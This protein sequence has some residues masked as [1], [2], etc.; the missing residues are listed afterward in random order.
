MD[1]KSENGKKSKRPSRLLSSFRRNVNVLSS[2]IRP[3]L[4]TASATA[5]ASASGTNVSSSLSAADHTTKAITSSNTGIGI[6]SSSDH[7]H[8]HHHHPVPANSNNSKKSNFEIYSVRDRRDATAKRAFKVQ[9]PKK[10]LYYTTTVFLI[11]PLALFLW[12]ELHFHPHHPATHQ[13]VKSNLDR[14][15]NNNHGHEVYPTW[16]EETF[17]TTAA[18]PAVPSDTQDADDS[19]TEAATKEES[20]E[21]PFADEILTAATAL[22]ELELF[23]S[24]EDDQ[25]AKKKNETAVAAVAADDTEQ[26]GLLSLGPKS[27]T[28][29]VEHG[30]VAPVGAFADAT[31]QKKNIHG[32]RDGDANKRRQ[33]RQQEQQ[34]RRV[35]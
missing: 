32:V 30:G 6:G 16:M 26:S 8:H 23:D 22:A 5:S 2:E 10:I 7:H 31:D 19:S 21:S 27:G 20:S 9:V 17:E 29:P 34:T 24:V 11:L 14:N 18:Q 33:L 35:D 28:A 4:P 15:S 12:K 3:F 1:D 13:L 25:N